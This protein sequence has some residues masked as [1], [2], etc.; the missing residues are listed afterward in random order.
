MAK[1]KNKAKE[2]PKLHDPLAEQIDAV[3]QLPKEHQKEG[4]KLVKTF[5][6]VEC[7]ITVVYIIIG[8]YLICIEEYKCAVAL[9]IATIYNFSRNS[10]TN[11]NFPTPPL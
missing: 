5:R 10:Y 3:S 6:W 1:N 4:L 7:I 2:Q 9:L 11:N 8:C